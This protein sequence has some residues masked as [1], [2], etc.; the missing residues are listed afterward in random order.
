MA[1]DPRLARG[2]QLPATR[3]DF[4]RRLG[5]ADEAAA[6]EIAALARA[7]TAPARADLTRRL[8]EATRPAGP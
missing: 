1:D 2:H 7:R 6:D 3:A 4:L 5:R 8:G